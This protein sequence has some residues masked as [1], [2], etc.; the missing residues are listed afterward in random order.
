MSSKNGVLSVLGILLM[1]LS[2]LAKPVASEESN[3]AVTFSKDV[4]P[5]LQKNCQS[6]HRPGQIGPF[7]M[8]SYKDTRPWAKAIKAAVTSRTMPPWFADPKYGHFDNDRSLKKSDVDTIVAW[9][10]SAA[11]EGD[12]KDAPSPVQWPKDGWQIPPDVVVELPPYPVPARGILDW[13]TLIIPAPFKEDTWV[14]S[15]EILPSEPAV[16]HHMR[17][18]FDKHQAGTIY[19]MYEWAEVPRDD[20]GITKKPGDRPA[21]VTVASRQVGSTEITRR[22]GRPLLPPGNVDFLYFPGL[23]Y[24]DYRPLNAGFLVRAGSDIIMNLHYTTNGLAVTDK[25]RLGFTIAKTPPARQV[26]PQGRDQAGRE[27]RKTDIAPIQQKSRITELA[28]PPYEGNYLA[29]VTELTFMKDTEIVSLNPHA[30]V[31]GKSAQYKL[32][33]P[34]GREEIILNVPRFDFNWQ[35]L[36]RTSIKVPKGSRLVV[37]FAFDNSPNNKYNPDPGRWVY[38]GEQSWEEMGTPFVGVVVDNDS[39]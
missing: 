2:T 30:H 21:E 10:D 25:S 26:L 23:P 9:V 13:Q 14:T 27:G 31:R 17:I 38:Y 6:C 39:N 1:S 15:V 19:N 28:I 32:I 24:T 22:Q 36:Y 16:V 29:P 11:T 37:Q 33:Y 7:S 8:L 20:E 4:L 3:A 35:L 12:P 34:D 5:I 18:G